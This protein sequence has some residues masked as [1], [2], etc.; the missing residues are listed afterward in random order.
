MIERGYSDRGVK[1]KS[2]DCYKFNPERTLAKRVL[3]DL[4]YTKSQKLPERYQHL[5]Q[6]YTYEDLQNRAKRVLDSLYIK[7]GWEK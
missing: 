7:D 3:V 1:K 6:E 5:T 4:I 2:Y